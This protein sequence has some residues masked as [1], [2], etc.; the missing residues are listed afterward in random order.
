MNTVT[1]RSYQL[2]LKSREYSFT[3]PIGKIAEQTQERVA[4]SFK[5]VYNGSV[6]SQFVNIWMA[7]IE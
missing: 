4:G 6:L 7:P 2:G 3:L 1:A 5:R